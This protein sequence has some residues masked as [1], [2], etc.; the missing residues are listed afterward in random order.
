MSSHIHYL[1]N[2]PS[3]VMENIIIYCDGTSLG[4]LM[5]SCKR[6]KQC[7][8]NSNKFTSKKWGLL[9][10]YEMEKDFV[11]DILQNLYPKYWLDEEICWKAVYISWRKWNCLK[12]WIPTVNK[13]FKKTR[14]CISSIKFSGNWIFIATKNEGVLEAV[15]FIT[16]E[17][18]LL[19]QCNSIEDIYLRCYTKKEKNDNLILENVE[20]DE[21]VIL[22][23]RQ[24]IFFDLHT[25][26]T[27]IVPKLNN[28]LTLKHFESQEVSVTNMGSP[29]LVCNLNVLNNKKTVVQR[30]EW[31]ISNVVQVW[32]SNILLLDYD[33]NSKNIGMF[34][35]TDYNFKTVDHPLNYYK[36]DMLEFLH[37][38]IKNY[39][40]GV[41]IIINGVELEII[42]DGRTRKYQ[43]SSLACQI[44]CTHY[45]AGVLLLGSSTGV[46]I[47]ELK[48]I[49][50]KKIVE[51]S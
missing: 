13:F 21:V 51:V 38:S 19:H 37:C 17:K 1:D 23:L 16:K 45:Y 2:L 36:I 7:I 44:L 34:E 48:K 42:V 31:M 20:H 35:V 50:K 6:W 49:T 46:K 24:Y 9:C 15:N 32:N 43:T 47:H 12:Y 29:S 22:L 25:G 5:K 26:Q 30:K 39:H 11:I 27:R 41:I 28:F 4:N 33:E 18:V 10:M 3:E 14:N 8:E 40:L